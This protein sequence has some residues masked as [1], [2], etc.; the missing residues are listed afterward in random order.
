[1]SSLLF[2]CLPNL[3]RCHYGI[4]I[5]SD[6]THNLFAKKIHDQVTN[7]LVIPSKAVG[8]STQLSSQ[9]FILFGGVVNAG[10]IKWVPNQAVIMTSWT[11]PLYV[12]T[13]GIFRNMKWPSVQGWRKG[14]LYCRRACPSFQIAINDPKKKSV[15][16]KQRTMN[17]RFLPHSFCFLLMIATLAT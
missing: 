2:L 7:K 6:M 9:Q 3:L 5:V 1:M 16:R 11:G 12:H 8:F 4:S 15:A 14:L 13:E 17:Q 10:Y